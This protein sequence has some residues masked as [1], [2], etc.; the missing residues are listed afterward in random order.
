MALVQG[1]LKCPEMEALEI[2]KVRMG[3]LASDSR[4][5]EPLLDMGEARECL[6]RQD[7]KKASQQQKAAKCAV[8]EKSDFTKSY[9][10]ERRR[11]QATAAASQA[12]RPKPGRTARPATDRPKQLPCVSSIPHSEAKRY[13]PEGGFVWR[14]LTGTGAWEAHFPSFPR[15]SRSWRRYGESEAL[16]LCLVELWTRWCEVNAQDPADC[17]LAGVLGSPADDGTSAASGSGDRR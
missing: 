3:R 7:E 4:W 16:R 1:V 12:K 8:E 5:C 10:S 11:V 13:A 17:P 2:M 15:I 9:I 14:C 6:D